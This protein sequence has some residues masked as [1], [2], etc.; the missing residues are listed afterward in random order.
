MYN[1]IIIAKLEAAKSI[2]VAVGI[3]L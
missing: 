3:E 1:K 2:K